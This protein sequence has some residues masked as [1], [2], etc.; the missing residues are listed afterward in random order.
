MRSAYLCISSAVPL[1]PFHSNSTIPNTATNS[2]NR[3]RV[4]K[5]HIAL[6]GG[7]LARAD[8]QLT[9]PL[10]SSMVREVTPS[11][12]QGIPFARRAA[13]LGMTGVARFR[14]SDS[15][16]ARREVVR[17]VGGRRGSWWGKERG[18]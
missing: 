12:A 16:E 9:P 17:I 10:G 11:G 14:C 13:S 8:F 18:W 4:M 5:F 3:V 2:R 7:N 15:G 6:L 1:K